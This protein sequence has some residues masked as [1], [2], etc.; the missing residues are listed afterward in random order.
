MLNLKTTS[1][2]SDRLQPPYNFGRCKLCGTLSAEPTY[3]L[4]KCT[5]YACAACGFHCIDAL[6]V[7]PCPA[8]AG[9]APELDSKAIAYIERRLAGSLPQQ[10][11][12][13]RRAQAC[14]PLFGAHC[15]DVGAGAG[16][17]AHLL[18][19]E[20][21]TVQGLEPQPVF[22]TF[23]QQKFGLTFRQETIDAPYWQ[24]GYAGAF[25]LITLW[26]VLEHVNFPAATLQQV[27]PLLK[28]GGYLLLDTPIRDALV[29]RF[30]EWAY[31]CSRGRNTFMLETL[32]SP[33]PFRHKQIFTQAQLR[34]L[35]EGLGLRVLGLELPWWSP[36]SQV[37]LVAQKACEG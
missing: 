10:Q 26:D 7:L 12:R 1:V 22:C 8:S 5:V 19:A 36:R 14:Q 24:H 25:D 34:R 27:V 4:K 33:R 9:E 31:R 13:L 23:A 29:Y 28:P 35:V 17:F 16:L 30:S 21:A 15:L 20:G 2:A 3:R 37:T 11:D 32:Y 18:A 6:D